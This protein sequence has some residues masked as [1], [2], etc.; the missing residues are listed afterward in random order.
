[1][2]CKV[3]GMRSSEPTGRPVFKRRSVFNRFVHF[4]PIGDGWHV[5]A[6]TD[7][8]SL[9]PVSNSLCKTRKHTLPT[10][11]LKATKIDRRYPYNTAAKAYHLWVWKLLFSKHYRTDLVHSTQGEGIPPIECIAQ[12]Y[13]EKKDQIFFFPFWILGMFFSFFLYHLQAD[14]VW[15]L[16]ILTHTSV[17]NT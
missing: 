12:Y 11:V 16:H 2:E 14:F 1:M 9:H 17:K 15:L 7:S 3:R 4:F 6:Q 8:N 13:S 10:V 5:E